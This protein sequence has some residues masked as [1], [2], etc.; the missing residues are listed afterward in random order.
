MND[1]SRYPY[2]ND[3]PHERPILTVSTD[4]PSKAWAWLLISLAIVA[5]ILFVR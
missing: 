1:L 5:L 3:P 4:V 2:F